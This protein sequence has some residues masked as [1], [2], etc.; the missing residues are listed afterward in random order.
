MNEILIT[1]IASFL[2]WAM[3]LGLMVLWIVDG[4]IKKE[5][6]LHA[7]IASLIA[8]LITEMIKSLVTSARPYT[9][10]GFEPLTLTV[11]GGDGFPSSHAAVAFA[12]AVTI[13]LHDKRV[14]IYYLIAAISVGIARIIA[15]VHFPIDII[16]GALI[17]ILVAIFVD[18][19]HFFKLVEKK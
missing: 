1:F 14:G 19:T 7:L 16:F 13:W 2:V 8:W 3:F 10:N 9:L 6:T 11:P 12:L 18:R 4:R 15:N 5:Q 17:G